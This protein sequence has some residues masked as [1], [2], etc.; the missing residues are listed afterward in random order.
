[1]NLLQKLQYLVEFSYKSNR[2]CIFYLH[3]IG[4]HDSFAYELTKNP[5]PDLEPALR[6]LSFFISPIIR[7]WSITQN[8]TFIGMKI[9][10]K[11]FQV[12]SFL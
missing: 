3:I 2:F 1:M 8:K 4:T 12:L 9:F 7:N 6:L 5:G 11:N 10:H